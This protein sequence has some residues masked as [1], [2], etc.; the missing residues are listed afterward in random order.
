MCVSK[1]QSGVH[2]EAVWQW[3]HP[4]LHYVR[5]VGLEGQELGHWQEGHLQRVFRPKSE[6]Q[7]IVTKYRGWGSQG[8]GGGLEVM[9]L[10][11]STSG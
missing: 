5:M 2:L 10:N 7:G 1:P 3:S 6:N 11:Q 8:A 4:Y 9:A